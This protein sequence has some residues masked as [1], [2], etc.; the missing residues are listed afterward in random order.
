MIFQSTSGITLTV[1]GRSVPKVSVFGTHTMKV[2]GKVIVPDSMVSKVDFGE[3]V[4]VNRLGIK[5]RY[6]KGSSKD[7]MCFYTFHWLNNMYGPRARE[8]LNDEIPFDTSLV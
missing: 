8:D 6:F 2:G 7:Q 3:I 1:S 5:V 4:E